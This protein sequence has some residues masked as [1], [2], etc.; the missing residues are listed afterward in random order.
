MSLLGVLGLGLPAGAGI[1]C[2][3][4]WMFKYVVAG[5]LAALVMGSQGASAEGPLNLLPSGSPSVA[6]ARVGVNAAA[7]ATYAAQVY[8][9][10]DY[11]GKPAAAFWGIGTTVG[12]MSL[13]PIVAGILVNANEHR[14]LTSREVHIMLADCT[15]PIVGGWLMEKYWDSIEPQAA[16]GQ[17]T[18]VKR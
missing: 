13:S 11:R 9:G 7:T 5:A 4:R 8:R 1:N 3:G 14:Q 2:V 15:I 16:A 17:G 18:Q 12:C 6:A 10:G